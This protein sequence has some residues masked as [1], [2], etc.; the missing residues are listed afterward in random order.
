MALLSQVPDREIDQR[1]HCRMEVDAANEYAWGGTVTALET[2][3]EAVWG[4][5][6]SSF[7]WL[8]RRRLST[9]PNEVLEGG[10]IHKLNTNGKSNAGESTFSEIRRN[11]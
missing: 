8:A 6:V 2:A 11:E 5:V 10:G 4:Y 7:R 1:T 9:S 3:T